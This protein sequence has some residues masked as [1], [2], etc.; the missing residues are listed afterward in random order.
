VTHDQHETF[1][2]GGDAVGVMHE[3]KL[4]RWDTPYN[5]YNEPA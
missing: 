4:L 2:P 5:L 1:A 3:G